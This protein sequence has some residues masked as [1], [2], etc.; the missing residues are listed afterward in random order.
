MVAKAL[1]VEDRGNE[2]V[3]KLKVR[4]EEISERVAGV[5]QCPRVACIEWFEPLMAAGNWVPELMRIAGGENL[6]GL[7]GEHSP[8]MEWT[9]LEDA[10]PEVIILMPCGFE[11][12]RSR[13]EMKA[14]TNHPSWSGLQ[15]VREQR[16]YVTDGNQYFNRPGP[17]LVESAEI[18]AEILHPSIFDF[19]HKGTGWECLV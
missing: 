9:I 8:W 11:I 12:P 2:L 19:G 17:R 10:Q 1:D 15:A 7:A 6:V 16:V 5:S 4:L 13:Q 18:L 3:A 14:L